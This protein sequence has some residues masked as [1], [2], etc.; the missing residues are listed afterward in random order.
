MSVSF[1]ILFTSLKNLS[2][3]I[4]PANDLVLAFCMTGPSA[5][6][7]E[8]GNPNSIMSTH[9]SIKPLTEDNVAFSFGYPAMI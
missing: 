1:L 7:S 5:I 8:N 6:G 3:L 4:P 9:P 2:I